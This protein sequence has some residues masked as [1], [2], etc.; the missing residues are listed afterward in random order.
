MC[1]VCVCVCVC[2]REREREIEQ[3]R[4]KET[5]QEPERKRII[6]GVSSDGLLH[7]NPLTKANPPR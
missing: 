7:L 1:V 2:V 5:G 3:E 6:F 4:K